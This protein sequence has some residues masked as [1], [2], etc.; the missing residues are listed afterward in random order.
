[1]DF[2]SW[3]IHIPILAWLSWRFYLKQQ[4]NPLAFCYWPALGLKLLAGIALNLVYFYYYKEG[5]LIFYIE[6][7]QAAIGL[8][9]TEPSVVI[10]FIFTDYFPESYRGILGVLENAPRALFFFKYLIVVFALCLNNYWIA[11]FYLSFL[12]FI[13]V[14]KLAGSLVDNYRGSTIPALIAFL[15]WPPFLFWSSGLMKDALT[16]TCIAWLVDAFLN[17]KKVSW[18]VWLSLLP[19]TYLLFKVKFYYVIVLPLLIGLTFA[20]GVGQR[21]SSATKVLIMFGLGLVFMLPFI[22]MNEYLNPADFL[23]QVIINHNSSIGSYFAKTGIAE[24]FVAFPDLSANVWSMLFYTPKALFTGL[25]EPLCWNTASALQ[26]L[27]GLVN[28]M[29]LTVS[30]YA[31]TFF[32]LKKGKKALSLDFIAVGVYVLIMA[33]LLTLASPSLG[34]L[35]RYRIG[36]MPFYMF[37]ILNAFDWRRSEVFLR[38]ILTIKVN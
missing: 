34:T 10:S 23:K 2:F 9:K 38:S 25:F 26:L 27:D 33:V 35:T 13:T 3:I 21:F 19:V 1:M 37:M 14:F 4:A 16:I 8:L 36:F 31:L 11:G 28:L 12:S 29:V 32:F 5:D 30:V 24:T 15:F 20:K 22:F 7:V 18:I 17:K 6:K